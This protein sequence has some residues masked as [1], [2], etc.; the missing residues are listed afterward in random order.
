MTI[1]FS[2]TVRTQ[3]INRF[4]RETTPYEIYDFLFFLLGLLLPYGDFLE[5]PLGLF[6]DCY[7][8]S[9]Y[10]HTFKEGAYACLFIESLSVLDLL[11]LGKLDVFGWIG[12]IP[13]WMLMAH[14]MRVKEEKKATTHPPTER[15][16][17]FSKK[18]HVCLQESY[19]LEYC[20]FCGAV[21]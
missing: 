8:F 2:N 21:L 4:F 14:S 11:F 7:L 17:I 10:R 3:R 9:K 19:T 5:A 20:E 18:C 1:R 6:I 12:I 16:T 15:R 13:I